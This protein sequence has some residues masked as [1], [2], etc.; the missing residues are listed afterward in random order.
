M[1]TQVSLEIFN[2]IKSSHA[3][4]G[5]RHGD[6]VRYRQYCTRR[7]HRIRKSVNFIHGTGSK[8]RFSKRTLEPQ[9]V[10]NGRHLMRPLY[11]AERAWSY[12]MA[13]KRENT[14][15]EPRPRFHLLQRLNKAAK[16]GCCVARP[17]RR[18]R[19]QAHGAGGR[20]V[21]GFHVGEYAPGA[22]AVGASAR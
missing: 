22:R 13:I 19:R 4:H 12:A 17:L 16:V 2:V 11:N 21:L 20:G 9:M 10:R 7:L 6:Y 3:Q 5:L 15:Q 18:A 14:A 1:N 8:G